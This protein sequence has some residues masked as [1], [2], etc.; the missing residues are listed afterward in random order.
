[1]AGLRVFNEH[2]DR[3]NRDR[4][5]QRYIVDEVGQSA[6][7][8]LVRAELAEELPRG[9]PAQ[10]AARPQSESALPSS[11]P[12]GSGEPFDRWRELNTVPQR[13]AGF[14]AVHLS[15]V[16]GSIEAEELVLLADIIEE[17]G[18]VCLRATTSQ[19]LM[20]R[21][22]RECDL[23][24][25]H[26]KLHGLASGRPISSLERDLVVCVGAP[27]C[28]RGI[29]QSRDVARAILDEATKRGIAEALAPGTRIHVSG[30]ANA[31]GRHPVGDIGLHCVRK[32]EDGA[33]VVQTGGRMGGDSA[34]L[35]EGET[36]V[37]TSEV[38]RYVV[39]LLEQRVG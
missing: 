14:R 16:L 32:G 24:R 6:F 11:R 3:Q 35:A 25:L 9:L 4:A 39:D 36:R 30:C 13:Q 18:E 38:A 1:V 15:S 19:H 26:G 34:R 17:H 27:T 23:E 20:I 5:R 8:D 28:R 37:P 33:Y 2:G 31:C 29:G 22:V 10:G 21:W 7:D 12:Q